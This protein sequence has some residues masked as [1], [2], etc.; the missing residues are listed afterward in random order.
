MWLSKLCVFTILAYFFILIEI[1]VVQLLIIAYPIV[2]I[3]GF[4]AFIMFI[5]LIFI[6][7]GY[8]ILRSARWMFLFSIFIYI[9]TS[10]GFVFMF[11]IQKSETTELIPKIILIG[12]FFVGFILTKIKVLPKKFN[13]YF[14]FMNII[15]LFLLIALTYRSPFFLTKVQ[16]LSL[17]L[18]IK[19]LSTELL[20]RII[21]L[22]K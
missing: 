7:V 12:A 4:I 1:S 20:K 2:Y 17:S 13:K 5:T 10:F 15:S 14:N 16:L 19:K 18:Y 21:V 3:W 11:I 8:L 22:T 6:F 9:I